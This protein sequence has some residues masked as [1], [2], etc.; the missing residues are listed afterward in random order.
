L[1]T[2]GPWIQPLG[3]GVVLGTAMSAQQSS[4]SLDSVARDIAQEA[5]SSIEN[6]GRM[7]VES[8]HEVPK[9]LARKK[10]NVDLI[11]GLAMQGG[12]A[13]EIAAH[14]GIGVTTLYRRFGKVI[15]AGRMLRNT[16]IRR[17]QFIKAVVDGDSAMLIWLG[18]QWLGQ[19]NELQLTGPDGGP[20][21]VN[22][23]HNFRSLS[24]EALVEHVRDSQKRLAA[25]NEQIAPLLAA[26]GETSEASGIAEGGIVEAG[27]AT[28]ADSDPGRTIEST[29]LHSGE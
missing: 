20:I 6:V 15:E 1:G 5:A 26:Q 9:P 10:V 29:E 27:S 14:A 2:L 25:I 22:H 24:R 11:R 7:I 12:T 28:K 18:R 19:K 3:A 16:S 23:E 13:E 17:K 8:A 4:P 21:E